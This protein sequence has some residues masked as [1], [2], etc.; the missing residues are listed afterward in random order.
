M[1]TNPDKPP[2]FKTWTRWYVLV[3]LFLVALILFFYFFTKKFA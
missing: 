1:E 2:L 3:I